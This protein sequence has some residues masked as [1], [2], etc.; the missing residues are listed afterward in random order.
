MKSAGPK[1]SSSSTYVVIP[2][3][4]FTYAEENIC[5]CNGPLGRNHLMF[6]QSIGVG[7][8]VNVSGKKTDPLLGTF[9]EEQGIIMV[10]CAQMF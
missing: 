3:N 7:C 8:I 5:R 9:C 10:C 2:P 4:N 6:L 1:S